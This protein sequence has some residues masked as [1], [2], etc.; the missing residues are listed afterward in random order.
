MKGAAYVLRTLEERGVPA[1]LIG[2]LALGAHGIARAT[3]DVDV[4][5]VDTAVLDAAF[6]SR[7]PALAAPEI[8]RGDAEDRGESKA[9]AGAAAQAR[10]IPSDR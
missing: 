10:V 2:G 7:V 3:L 8:R 4:L 1:A 9:V 6:W 5:V